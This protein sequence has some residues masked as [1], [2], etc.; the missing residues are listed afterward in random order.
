MILLNEFLPERWALRAHAGAENHVQAKVRQLA[1]ARV[2][3]QSIRDRQAMVR[4]ILK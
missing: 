4:D 2:L 1:K 3:I